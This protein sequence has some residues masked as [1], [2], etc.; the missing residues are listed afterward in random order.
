MASSTDNKI[1]LYTC[2][3][4]PW[5]HR[6]YI[7]LSELGLPFEEVEIDLGRPRDP[8]ILKLIPVA[9]YNGETITE[10]AI[11]AQFLADA[12][13]SHLVLPSNAPGGALQR[14]RI[15]FFVDASISQVVA[16]LVAFIG[17]K[18]DA[19]G[20]THIEAYIEGVVKE[21]EPLLK[22]AKPFFGGSDN[23]TLAEALTGSFAIHL[24][25]LF[26]TG[27]IPSSLELQLKEKAP[28]FYAWAVAV[29]AHP[30][31]TGIFNE[32]AVVDFYKGQIE[33]HRSPDSEH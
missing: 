26:K 22:D 9:L 32:K 17:A 33:K 23:L 21:L 13:P 10:S 24:L 3:I 28:A 4:C 8:S 16:N 5:A 31:V 19:E 6:I 30:S 27:V 18:T 11:I 7:V 14:A 2:H 25:A 12:H 15:G 1:T 29:S 20:A